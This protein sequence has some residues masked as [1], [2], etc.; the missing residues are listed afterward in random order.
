[1][2]GYTS[3]LKILDER[4]V[5]SDEEGAM[6]FEFR[7]VMGSGHHEQQLLCASRA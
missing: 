4:L 3:G 1:M 6:Q 2:A 7:V 5:V